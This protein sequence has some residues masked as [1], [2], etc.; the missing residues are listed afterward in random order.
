MNAETKDRLQQFI[1]DKNTSN[2]V[3]RFLRNELEKPNGTYEVSLL[4]AE[5]LALMALKSAWKA[6]EKLS[7]SPSD[8]EKSSTNIGL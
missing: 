2:A 1:G 3:Y 5:R 8:E 6:L 7:P 4:A